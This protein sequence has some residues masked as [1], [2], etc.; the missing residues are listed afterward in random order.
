LASSPSD[1][2]FGVIVAEHCHSGRFVVGLNA[3]VVSFFDQAN[4]LYSVVQVA[5]RQDYGK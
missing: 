4:D 5:S 3:T 1:Q 2:S